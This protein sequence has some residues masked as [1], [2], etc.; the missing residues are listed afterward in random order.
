[1]RQT[2][3]DRH[4]HTHTS[5]NN[6]KLC[7]KNRKSEQKKKTMMMFGAVKETEFVINN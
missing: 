4:T 6:E 2:K 7:D 3:T 5:T 1:M